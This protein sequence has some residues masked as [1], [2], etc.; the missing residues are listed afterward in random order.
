MCVVASAEVSGIAQSLTPV[1]TGKPG[2][3]PSQEEKVASSAATAVVSAR[4]GNSSAVDTVSISD[5]S[6]QAI[7]DVKKED[8]KKEEK[9]AASNVNQPGKAAAKVEF[10]YDPKGELSVRF[11][12][13]AN[14][15]IYQV[16]S[17]LM[18]KL[19]EV[20]YK[21]DSSVNTKA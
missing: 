10:V 8:V 1:S 3:L 12:D 11:M 15:V 19:E 6:R 17:E 2:S 4:E 13:T 14:R 20:A 21:P 16:P 5:M 7:T 18:M 9:N